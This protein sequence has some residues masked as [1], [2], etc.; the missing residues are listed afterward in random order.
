MSLPGRNAQP[1][2]AEDRRRSQEQAAR[3]AISL[4]QQP[5]SED[6]AQEAGAVAALARAFQEVAPNL[7]DTEAIDAA[8]SARTQG[9]R[10]GF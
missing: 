7:T 4:M 8:V 3:D 9:Q 2:F 1:R 5:A 10:P 6:P